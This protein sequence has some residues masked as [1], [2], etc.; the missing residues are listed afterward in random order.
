M[1]DLNKALNKIAAVVQRRFY[2]QAVS[3]LKSDSLEDLTDAIERCT[4][5]SSCQPEQWI[6]E[7]RSLDRLDH[8]LI[9]TIYCGSRVA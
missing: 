1:C 5:R 4:R 2:G 6:R 3:L 9:A 7:L 8:A